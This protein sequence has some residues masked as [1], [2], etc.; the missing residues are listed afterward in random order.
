MPLADSGLEIDGDYAFSEQPV[1]GAM[2]AV[3]IAGGKL[4]RQKR[5]AQLFV[6]ADLTPHAGVAGVIGGIA[7]PSVVAELAGFWDGVEDPQAFAG[8]HVEG[9][10]E[11]FH[12]GLAARD[13]AGAVRGAYDDG[14]V[15]DDGR[16]V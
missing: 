10:H 15:R 9:A 14:V 6:D 12:V 3:V 2:A 16:G 8:A 11:T 5:Q 1:A 7:F 4:D 13:A